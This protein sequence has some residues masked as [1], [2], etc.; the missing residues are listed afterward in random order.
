MIV[1]T[2]FFMLG[3][4]FYK[5]VP[6]KENVI[7]R[8]AGVMKVAIRNKF[9]RSPPVKRD[10]WIEYFLDTHKCEN[11]PKCLALRS[12]KRH[13]KE[14]AQTKFVDDIKSLVRVTIMMLPVPMFWALYDQQGSR[15]IIQAVAMDA[16]LTSGFALLPDQMATLNAILIMLFIPLFQIII[17]PGFEKMGIRTTSLR[18][19]V[20]GGLLAA[21]A[22]ITS[23]FVQI[24]VN[25]TLPDVPGDSTAFL[26]VINSFPN[27]SSCFVNVTIPGVPGASA[28]SIPA[29]SSLIDDNVQKRKELYRL[30]TGDSK[31][32]EVNLAFSGTNCYGHKSIKYPVTLEGGKSY[33]IAAT[34]QGILHNETHWDKPQEGEGQNAVSIN[35]VSPCNRVS[36]NVTWANCQNETLKA[37]ADRLALCAYD[38]TE[39][40][41][42]CNPRD[43]NEYYYWKDIDDDWHIEN[44]TAWKNSVDD[45]T[46]VASMTVYE[47]RDVKKGVYRLYYVKYPDGNSDRTPSSDQIIAIPVNDVAIEI[48]G[49]GAVFTLTVSLNGSTT[50]SVSTNIHN[51]HVI[52]PKNHVSILWQVPQYVIITAGEILFSITGL[53]FSY[54]QAAPSMKSVVQAIWLF[55]V[56][57]GDL[58]IIIIALIPESNLA[59]EMFVFAGA[60]IV[61]VGIFALMAVFYYEYVDYSQGEDDSTASTLSD[62]ENDEISHGKINHGYDKAFDTSSDLRLRM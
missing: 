46:T 44:F 27:A 40:Q 30:S 25:E 38:G 50:D 14:C 11:D 6:P 51:V 15:W 32:F 17:Y 29:N 5:K 3:S 52:V 21:A 55:T 12:S 37:Y 9:F 47:F 19:M 35:L 26:S 13:S 24:A 58:I 18:R 33:Y 34:P 43:A 8:V 39:K 2:V 61:V 41:N 56:A 60:M 54:S 31:S 22:F 42:P 53:E 1:A 45:N 23:G 62:V 59:I 16:Q 7:F 20:I 48:T 28:Y 4:F 36:P 10:H 57:I 49:M